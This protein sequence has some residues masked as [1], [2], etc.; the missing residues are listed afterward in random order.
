[1][2]VPKSDAQ[3]SNSLPRRQQIISFTHSTPE[4]SSLPSA[5]SFP[6]ARSPFPEFAPPSAASP[7][8]T[9]HEHALDFATYPLDLATGGLKTLTAK[10]ELP[11]RSERYA[12]GTVPETVSAQRSY[13]LTLAIFACIVLMLIGGGVVLFVMLQ[14]Y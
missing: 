1:V 4:A 3:S 14:P 6:P 2:T 7:E 5:S 13:A 12:S 9:N 8:P 10:R 11:S